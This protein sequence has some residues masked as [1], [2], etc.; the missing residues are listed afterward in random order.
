MDKRRI[1]LS[2]S[3]DIDPRS[4]LLELGKQFNLRVEHE[5][6]EKKENIAWLEIEL[7]GES[8]AIKEALTWAIS[9][10]V[11]AEELPLTA[12]RP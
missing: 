7:E 8:E 11:R 1:M 4:L 3:S 10:G 6:P 12:A 2:F 9:R 5:L